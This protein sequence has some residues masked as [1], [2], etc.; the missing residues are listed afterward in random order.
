MDIKCSP[1]RHTGHKFSDGRRLG[2]GSVWRMRGMVVSITALAVVTALFSTGCSSG[3]KKQPAVSTTGPVSYMVTA[4]STPF[5]KYGPQQA[6]GADMQL[7]RGEEVVML[8]R[9]YGYSRVQNQ[10]G[11]SGYVAT[12]DVIPAPHQQNLASAPGRKTGGHG[13]S[14]SGPAKLGRGPDFD[15][16]N[17][18]PLPSKQPPSDEPAPSYRY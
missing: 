5:Y 13:S 1:V 16:P 18:V 7:K 6:N 12:E 10:G 9:H 14:G 4:D 8:E 17:D 3:G 15:Q 2:M 11:D